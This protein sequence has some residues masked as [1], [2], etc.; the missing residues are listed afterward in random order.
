[1]FKDF[2]EWL[3]LIVHIMKYNQNWTIISIFYQYRY[4][5]KNISEALIP[6]VQF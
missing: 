5:K 4:K 2:F 6:E 1:M 3:M